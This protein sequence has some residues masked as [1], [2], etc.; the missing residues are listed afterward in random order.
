[1][2]EATTIAL[3]TVF[4]S[5]LVA[6]LGYVITAVAQLTKRLHRLEHRDRLSWLY[7]RILIDHIYVHK[8]TPLPEPP[9]GWLDDPEE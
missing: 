4:G 5:V 9:P 3:L 7:I 1:M 8:A 2:S 6:A